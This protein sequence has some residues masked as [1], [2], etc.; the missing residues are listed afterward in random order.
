RSREGG[1]LPAKKSVSIFSGWTGPAG[2]W[3]TGF[4]ANESG[5]R[6]MENTP[7]DPAHLRRE[8]QPCRN[9]FTAFGGKTRQDLLRVLLSPPPAGSAGDRRDKSPKR[10]DSRL[11][12]SGPAGQWDR[13]RSAPVR[14]HSADPE[15][16]S[17]QER[18]GLTAAITGGIQLWICSR[19]WSTGM[20]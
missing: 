20:R 3:Y 8:F 16:R 1:S 17:G 11:L 19:P 4:S 6:G 13:K 7:Q 9:R 5:G 15:K 14:G 18:R 2:M 12:L 10:S